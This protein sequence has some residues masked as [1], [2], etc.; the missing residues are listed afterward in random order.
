MNLRDVRMVDGGGHLGLVNELLPALPV[1]DDFGR[2]DLERHD[3]VQDGVLGLPH[4]PHPAL[5]DLL[6]KAVLGEDLVGLERHGILYIGWPLST[7]TETNIFS[8]QRVVLA[9][10]PSGEPISHPYKTGDPLVNRGR[11]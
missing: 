7:L 10:V 3:P 9:T 8:L 6:D 4:H 5:A 2:K 1:G 11:V